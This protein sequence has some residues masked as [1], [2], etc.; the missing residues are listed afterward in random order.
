MLRN[1][2]HEIAQKMPEKE[3]VPQV[4]QEV[5]ISTWLQMS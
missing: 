2:A 1:L 4:L 3:L 5:G